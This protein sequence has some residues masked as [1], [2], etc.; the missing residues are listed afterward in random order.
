MEVVTRVGQKKGRNS[1][2][3][4]GD[5]SVPRAPFSKVGGEQ[6]IFCLTLFQHIQCVSGGFFCDFAFNSVN[7]CIRC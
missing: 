7:G 5:R 3:F 4:C 6:L 2:P 1:R